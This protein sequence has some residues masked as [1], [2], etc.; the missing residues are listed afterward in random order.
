[1]LAD[2]RALPLEASSA[3]VATMLDVVEHLSPL[4][5]PQALGEGRRVLRRR[6]ACSCTPFRTA[7]L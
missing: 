7:G 6:A 2:A 4:E 5:L 3:D 1:M